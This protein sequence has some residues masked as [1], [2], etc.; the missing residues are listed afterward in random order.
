MYQTELPDLIQD[1]V[2]NMDLSMSI[3]DYTRSGTTHT[4]EVCDV[5]WLQIGRTITIDGSDY[6]IESVNDSTNVIV[7]TGAASDI[8]ANT[9]DIYAPVFF[10]GTPLEQDQKLK[11]IPNIADKTPMFYLL[12]TYKERNI[13][14]AEDPI[15]REVTCRIF[16]L[17]SS[18]HE[19]RTDDIQSLYV[20]P[21]SRMCQEFIDTMKGM[22]GTFYTENLTFD[23]VPQHKF[24]VYITNTG[25]QKS[26]FADKLSGIE[27]DFDRLAV[28][29]GH[30]C[31]A[32]CRLYDIPSGIGSMIIGDTFTIA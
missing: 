2:D 23:T 17:T 26:F 1:V 10:Y 24:G 32:T 11:A 16:G 5:K 12:L 29:K 8:T 18:V 25:T 19:K 27:I 15:E 14:D 6:K 7:C 4:I 30:V 9:F 20:K 13:A 3:T 31:T 21:M 22:K 28:R